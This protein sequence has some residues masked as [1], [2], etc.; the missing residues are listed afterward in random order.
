MLSRVLYRFTKVLM[1]ILVG[2]VYDSTLYQRASKGC[3][4]DLDK[5]YQN[6]EYYLNLTKMIFVRRKSS[7]YQTR[8]PFSLFWNWRPTRMR[9]TS[10]DAACPCKPVFRL[11]MRPKDQRSLMIRISCFG[12]PL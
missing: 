4:L 9:Y 7:I 10:G 1:S 3:L 2:A 5:R 12:D 8:H 11:L 6:T